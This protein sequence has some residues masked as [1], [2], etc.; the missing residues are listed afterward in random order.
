MITTR[1]GSAR[2]IRGAGGGGGAAR[3]HRRPVGLDAVELEVRT[4]VA[5]PGVRCSSGCGRP[6]PGRPGPG[7]PGPGGWVRVAQVS[8]LDRLVAYAGTCAEWQP[9]VAK[10]VK[11]RVR[12]RAARGAQ[13]RTSSRR[14]GGS[15]S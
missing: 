6:G 4:A 10:I 13:S 5:R 15:F 2:R 7:R 8:E 14:D 9:L 12:R 11:L 1:R 3:L